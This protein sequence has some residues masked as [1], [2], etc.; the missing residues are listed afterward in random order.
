MPASAPLPHEIRDPIHGVIRVTVPE[1]AVIEHPFVQRLRGIRQLGFSQLPFP[2][3]THT[4][5]AHSLGALELAGRAFDAALSGAAL[6]ESRRSAW[7]GALRLAALCHDL[8]HPPFSHAV[9][10]A[11]PPLREVAVDAYDPALV[12]SRLNWRASHE[13]YTVAILTRSSLAQT[14]R[15]HFPFE[16]RHVAALISKD[17]ALP[18]GDDFFM[19][20]G[21]DF[22]TLL[23]QL[24]SS[25]LDV[26]RLDYLVRDSYYTGAHYGNIDVPWLLS[27]LY[28]HVDAQGRV[29]LAL[30]HRAIYAFDDLMIARFHMFVMVYFHQKSIACEVMLQRY[31]EDPGCGYRLPADLDEYLRHDDAELTHHLRHASDPWARGLVEGRLWR[32]ALEVHGTPGEVHL[33]PRRRLLE[34]AG[35]P[36]IPS[37]STGAVFKSEARTAPPIYVIDRGH[38]RPERV[39]KL[40]EATRLFRGYE[41]ERAI[42]R[43]YV[44]GERAEEAR[45]MLSGAAAR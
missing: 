29:L 32:V 38:G 19:E 17:V 43:L 26:D 37:T 12:R 16:P 7:R 30:D 45:A 8:G 23:S 39:M 3:A 25:E 4:R 5:Y 1:L 9:E 27:H 36:V 31:M 21:Q 14:I 24:V 44:P 33:E 41:D 6:S 34:A 42:A 2:G 10:F 15:D 22:R 35:I 40:H 11:M 28:H 20:G 18:A 13:D